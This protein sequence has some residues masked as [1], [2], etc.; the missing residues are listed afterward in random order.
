MLDNVCPLVAARFEERRNMLKLGALNTG[1]TI[2]KPKHRIRYIH[3]NHVETREYEP[4]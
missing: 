4:M 3:Q 1:W 2:V